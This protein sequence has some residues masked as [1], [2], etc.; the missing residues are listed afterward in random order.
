VAKSSSR[1][2]ALHATLAMVNPPS[3]AP[4][5]VADYV[6][7]E[8][9]AAIRMPRGGWFAWL[10]ISLGLMLFICGAVLLG[11]AVFADR[12]A[13]WRLGMPLTLF[14]QAT[15][16]VGLV[17]HLDSLWTMHRQTSQSLR[18][19]GGELKQL[20][21]ATT[22]LTSSHSTAAQSFYVHLA[23]RASPH[24]LLADLKGQLDLLAVR[25][26]QRDDGGEGNEG[27]ERT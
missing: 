11:W 19:L 6:A 25:L 8:P 16:I 24:L 2:D 18:R 17:L 3:P 21:H 23:E 20:E 22:L 13:L 1:Q 14:G 27:T 10:V 9:A 4:A 26:S 5:H 15:L 12:A 7:R